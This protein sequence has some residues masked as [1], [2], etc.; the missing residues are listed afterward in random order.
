MAK[1]HTKLPLP[2]RR[3]PQLRAEPKHGIQAAIRIQRE[4]LRADIRLTDDGIALVE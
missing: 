1:L 4:I 3:R 2:L